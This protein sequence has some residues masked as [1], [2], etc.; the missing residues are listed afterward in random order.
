MNLI[1]RSLLL[2]SIPLLLSA[3]EIPSVREKKNI[4]KDWRF[5]FGH[6]YD[7]QKDFGNGNSYFSYFAKAGFGDGAA[8]AAFDD[9]AWR[10]LDLPHDWAVEQP[11]SAKAGYS[12][13][14]K[15]VGRDFPNSSVGWYRKKISIPESDLGKRI[16][17]VFDGVF[18]NSIVWVNGHYLGQE[19]SGYN[20]F[21]YDISD[22]LNYGGEN[23]IAVRVDATM[24]EGWFYEGAGIYRHV[25]L[26]KTAPIHVVQNGTFVSSEISAQQ[27][28]LTI[29]TDLLNETATQE[30]VLLIQ[31]IMDR[32]GKIVAEQKTNTQG[33]PSYKKQQINSSVTIA[34]P[35]LWDVTSPYLYTLITTV[36]HKGRAI[37]TYTTRFGI[38]S[39]RFDAQEGFFL[40]GKRVELKGTNNHQDHAG[41]G[42]AMPDSLQR[43]R[44]QTLK[45]WGNNAY[46]CSHHPPSP[47][48]LDLCDELG[49]LVIDEN[50]LMR[51]TEGGLR[52]IEKM[53]KRDRNHPSVISWS[54]G[55]EEWAIEGGIVGERIVATLQNYCK[56]LDATR[57]TTAGVSNGFKSGISN[58]LE[59]M[60]YNYL[61]NGDIDDHYKKFPNQP[62]MGTEEGSTFA[63]RGIY[64]TDDQLHYRAAYDQKPRPTF[65]SIEEG[66]KFY[67]S[68]KNLAGVFYW[69]GF[70]Y[71]GEATP[72]SW[73]SVMSYFG[74]MDIC[75]FPKDNVFYLKSW[76][77]DEPSLH[78]LPHWNWAGKEG[79]EIAV[80]VYSNCE[81]VE[82]FLNG[83]SKG[84][85]KM[86][87]NGH[88]EWKLNYTPGTVMAVGYRNGKK[89]LTQSIK[90]TGSPQS[91][92]LS[93]GQ[94][95]IKADVAAV[96]VVK[97][98]AL[99]QEQ[100]PVPI[101]DNEIIFEIEGPGK[102][103]GVGNGNQTSLEK[104]KF[105]DS[106]YTL[107]ISNFTERE[108]RTDVNVLN[109]SDSG[110][111]KAFIDRDYKKLASAY[112]YKG[113]FTL[114]DNFKESKIT[115]FHKNIGKQQT[116]WVN[117]HLVAADLK[118]GEKYEGWLL[119]HAILKT[120]VNTIVIQGTALPKK[121]EWEMPNQ[122]PGLIQVIMPA[123][124]WKRKLFSGLA[125]VI[126]QS[127]GEKGVIKLTA[128]SA[129]LKVGQLVIK[130][131]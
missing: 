7:T 68:R 1:K 123:K 57:P 23:T 124:S 25:W 74:M 110:R 128:T 104:E 2:L 75:G 6:P 131:E 30:E 127:T 95:N 99:D 113:E 29:Q 81:E 100:L 115:L 27:A 107:A 40:N 37:D 39:I 14:Y 52:D 8:A 121:Y 34:N 44:I 36:E 45:S 97:V 3:Q 89:I 96:S 101:A 77:K 90:T 82:L 71:R 18:R 87:V 31:R 108:L 32:E 79:Q 26:Q 112:S 15:A 10:Q 5:A 55:N 43:W 17:L 122:D 13:G 62:G 102:I 47:E 73:P 59:V 103:I 46:R 58:N 83:K 92:K 125:Q 129:G 20:Q 78:I 86:E 42:T 64:F 91:I 65:Y 120:G 109:P 94:N 106:V 11:F 93:T 84:K 22:L 85:K 88:L 41:V 24:E 35:K 61:G 50:R 54:V 69:T 119:N 116:I 48:L 16:S 60:G 117:G 63:T 66:W 98:E 70:D 126:V 118:E 114:P 38:R 9:R 80:W 12:H 21:D 56:S 105:V 49:M 72:Y 28:K 51:T 33:L 76:W 130:A 111:I 4:D 67:A 19:P 53:I